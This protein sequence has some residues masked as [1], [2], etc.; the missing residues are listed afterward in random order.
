M[1]YRVPI[2]D[3]TGY[4]VR[5]TFCLYLHTG[6]SPYSL[7][8]KL[9]LAASIR[10]PGMIS[11]PNLFAYSELCVQRH[12]LSRQQVFVVG[13]RVPTHYAVSDLH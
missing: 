13:M 6:A 2:A 10:R 3:N 4:M 7:A 5:S 9:S 12:R 1:E 8:G 11:L